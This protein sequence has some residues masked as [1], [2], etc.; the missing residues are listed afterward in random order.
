MELGSSS[1]TL[2]DVTR[3]VT[4]EG[5]E[6]MS[7]RRARPILQLPVQPRGFLQ[8]LQNPTPKHV[9]ASIFVTQVTVSICV[10]HVIA[11]LGC[12]YR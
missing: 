3:S 11:M 5:D 2:P 9:I 12:C 7:L 10:V 8:G 6:V 4:D 1:V